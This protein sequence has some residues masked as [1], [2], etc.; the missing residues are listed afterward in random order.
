MF[1]G[2]GK[3][4]ALFPLTHPQAWIWGEGGWE[5]R[6][7]HGRPAS[8]APIRDLWPMATSLPVAVLCVPF[9]PGA[10]APGK[11]PCG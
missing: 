9:S 7:E 1:S 5:M 11:G 2:E 4:E 3:E 6:S 8:S 10:L